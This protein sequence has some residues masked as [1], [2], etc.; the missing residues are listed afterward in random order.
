M[1]VCEL[2][3]CVFVV[4][5]ISFSLSVLNKCDIQPVYWFLFRFIL[6]KLNMYQHRIYSTFRFSLSISWNSVISEWERESITSLFWLHKFVRVLIRLVNFY[7]AAIF[8]QPPLPSLLSICRPNSSS[9]CDA[10]NK[11]Y[12]VWL[13]FIWLNRQKKDSYSDR[14]TISFH[15]VNFFHCPAARSSLCHINQHNGKIV[16]LFLQLAAAISLSV[17]FKYNWN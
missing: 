15:I 12:T 17:F 11:W 16:F 13:A 3:L 2:H 9:F 14:C 4:C 8:C 7:I 1:F 5:S 10:M 6:P